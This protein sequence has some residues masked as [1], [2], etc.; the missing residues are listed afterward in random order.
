MR[1]LIE[2]FLKSWPARIVCAVESRHAEQLGR[3]IFEGLPYDWKAVV[4]NRPVGD[5]GANRK[6][7]S[8]HMSDD[9]PQSPQG[10]SDPC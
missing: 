9:A 7:E 10:G 5:F 8:S 4:F 1:T 2:L 3:E 6:F